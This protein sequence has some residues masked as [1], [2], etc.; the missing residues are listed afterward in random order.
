M[1][2]RPFSGRKND[3]LLKRTNV[4]GSVGRPQGISSND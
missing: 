3:S 1:C 2:P 4:S